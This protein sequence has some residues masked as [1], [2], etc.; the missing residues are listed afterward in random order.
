MMAN[1]VLSPFIDESYRITCLVILKMHIHF[2]NYG[3]CET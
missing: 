2:V 1:K 3:Y